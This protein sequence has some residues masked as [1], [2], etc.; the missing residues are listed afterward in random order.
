MAETTKNPTPWQA[1]PVEEDE[2]FDVI[3]ANWD[4]AGVV[5][6]YSDGRVDHLDHRDLI[7]CTIAG[8]GSD[9]F[10]LGDVDRNGET[11]FDDL[12]F[13]LADWGPCEGE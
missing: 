8:E 13:V 5:L 12:L 3:D 1:V 4:S 2:W 9:P 10:C 11:N 7:R 6:E